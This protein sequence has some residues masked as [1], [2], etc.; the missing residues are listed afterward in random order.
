MRELH[1]SRREIRNAFDDALTLSTAKSNST[2]R[3]PV[4]SAAASKRSV[5]DRLKV[6]TDPKKA[7]TPASNSTSKAGAYEV[8]EAITRWINMFL[9]RRARERELAPKRGVKL[10]PLQR[11]EEVSVQ[12]MRLSIAEFEI[13]A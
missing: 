6:D 2:P 3:L 13:G 10:P 4:A 12:Q 5:L 7:S 8:D 1:K 11:G 9:A